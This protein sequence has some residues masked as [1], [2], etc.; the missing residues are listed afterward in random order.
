VSHRRSP[1]LVLLIAVA[2]LLPATASAA[3]GMPPSG[4]AP[5]VTY[6]PAAPV[7]PMASD[8]VVV[9]FRDAGA[10]SASARTHGARVISGA[11]ATNGT[12]RSSM[13]REG[14]SVLHTNGR[15]VA[16]L[17]AE[18]RRDP[19]IVW[20][21]PDYLVALPDDMPETGA[22]ESGTVAA[23]GTDDPRLGEQY[24]LQRMQVPDAWTITR[25]GRGLVAV[26][27]T[28]VQWTH[29]DLAGRTAINAGEY[30]SGRQSNGRDDDA[31]G[32][33]DDWR[34]WDFVADDNDPRDDNGHGTWV[35]GIIGAVAD[36]GIGVAGISWT[37]P[38]LVVKVMSANGTGYSSDLAFGVDY[39]VDRGAK[40][41]N[42][43][44]G[45]FGY[46][47]LLSE[48]VLHAW[49]R[50]AVIVAA[51]GNERT[52]QPSYPAAYDHVVGVSAT[53]ADDEFTNWSNYGSAV[54]VA[55]P[56]AA[57]TTT[58]CGG[59]SPASAGT[60]GYG[61]ISGT[62]FATP[63][64]AGVVALLMARFPAESNQQIVNR[65]VGSVDDLGFRGWDNRYGHGRVN[66]Y[67]ALG[68]APARSVVPARD[69]FE[70]N[71]ALSG[72]RRI[73]AGVVYPAT[74]YP[75]GDA[76]VFAVDA[77]RAGAVQFSVTAVVDS[78][79]MPKS[80]LPVDPIVEVFNAA[81]T[82]LVRMD[83]DDPAVAE[84]AR[85]RATGP[86]RF[87]VRVTNW[88]PNGTTAPYS[89]VGAFIDDVAPFATGL[90]PAPGAA[91]VTAYERFSFTFSE[92]VTG[93]DGSSVRLTDGGATVHPATVSYDPSRRSVTVTPTAPLP[94]SARVYLLIGPDVVDLGGNSLSSRAWSMTTA[95]GLAFG[96]QRGVTI[97]AGTHTG[98]RITGSGGIATT[99]TVTL[100]RPS[101]AHAGQRSTLPGLP[102]YWLHIEDGLWAGMWIP[103]GPTR[104]LLGGM[105]DRDLAASVTVRAGSYTLVRLGDGDAVVQ[106]RAVSLPSGARA[107]DRR[108]IIDG[109]AYLRLAGGTYGGYWLPETDSAYRAGIVDRV[110]F[111][112]QRRVVL[113]SGTHTGTARTVDGSITSATTATLPADSGASATAFAI[114]NGR[115][116][117]WI[118]NGVWANT[119]IAADVVE[120]FER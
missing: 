14:A 11:G 9:R 78:L 95:N 45:G 13:A 44:V 7:T 68:G 89:I 38:V 63:N 3:T 29:P 53:Q 21:E 118:V 98:Y 28:G 15:R 82:R 102:G 5:A 65:L 119:W 79:R 70:P 10:A 110:D 69:A 90:S 36:N 46:S 24:S 108:A 60:P 104:R 27:D 88:Y 72:A 87:F 1:S 55:A 33:V 107:T 97:S 103:E 77:P 2:T 17:L 43:S 6:D 109:R 111:G 52:S 75:A 74:M 32:L 61:A 62:S 18:L 58:D 81:G 19:G 59:C 8:R 76:D 54:D 113:S 41:I 73:T 96:P 71:D 92:P 117:Y 116:H 31:N 39:A 16:D 115:A 47:Q 57:V 20:A 106:R 105:P 48:A 85:V 93:V 40:V 66:A 35:S 94:P 56:G 42:L 23:V 84:V 120:R 51:A 64:T 37:N 25:G 30:G 112:R 67:R 100:P 114:I 80:A 101:G 86:S 34:G 83:H 99:K 26:L 49:Q 12:E 50:G 22:A 91:L 4:T